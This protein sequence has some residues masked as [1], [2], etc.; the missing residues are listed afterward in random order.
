MSFTEV[1]PCACVYG[2]N[3]KG[4]PVWIEADPSCSHCRGTG[5]IECTYDLGTDEVCL[6]P[7]LVKPYER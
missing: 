7:I 4:N 6:S 1:E 3:E 2:K 5:L